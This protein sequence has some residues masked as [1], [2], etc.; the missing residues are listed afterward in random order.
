MNAVLTLIIRLLLI[1]LC[2][3]FVGWIAYLIYMDL[4]RMRSDRKNISSIPIKLLA[5]T[6]DRSQEKTFQ[7]SAIII[8]RDP[9]VDFILQDDRVSLRHCKIEYI[10]NQWWV[11]DLNSTNGTYVND[12]LLNTRIVLMNNDQLRLG[13]IEIDVQI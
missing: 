8:G 5:K 12:S 9:A 2:Y 4:K 6:D 7:K 11:E 3:I 10:Q 1:L 13:N